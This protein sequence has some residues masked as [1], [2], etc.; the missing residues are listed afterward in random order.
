[1]FVRRTA[2][3]GADPYLPGCRGVI[4]QD[5]AVSD[6]WEGSIWLAVMIVL[7][8]VFNLVLQDSVAFRFLG[9]GLVAYGGMSLLR[10]WRSRRRA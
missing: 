6:R 5:D 3:R 8:G 1:M 10:I 9:V 7:A 2:V 4:G